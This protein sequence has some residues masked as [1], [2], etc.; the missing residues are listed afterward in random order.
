MKTTSI[1]II[2]IIL[3]I[4]ILV[5]YKYKSKTKKPKSLKTGGLYTL[6]SKDGTYGVTKILALDDFTVH[7]R[8][9]S[10][11]F[12]TKP[13]KINSSE[14]KF[15]IGHAP[16]AREGFLKD[17]QELLKVEKVH[18]SELEGYHYYLKATRIQ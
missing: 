11:T 2:I 6:Q 13:T 10:N 12:N 18:E 1:V 8:M 9:Y 16:M 15:S 5:V 17:K 3:L 14:L 7:A 4:S